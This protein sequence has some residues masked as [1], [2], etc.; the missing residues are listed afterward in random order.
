MA[1]AVR[2]LD[3]LGPGVRHAAARNPRLPAAVL[4]ALLREPDTA[5]VAAG[6]PGLPV[7]VLRALGRRA[8]APARPES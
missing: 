1:S 6:N 4:V 2:L 7:Q 8:G 5:A 3:D